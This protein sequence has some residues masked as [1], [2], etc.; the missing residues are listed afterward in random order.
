MTSSSLWP[1]CSGLY[2]KRPAGGLTIHYSIFCVCVSVFVCM[3]MIVWSDIAANRKSALLC[4]TA[5]EKK[6]VN[7]QNN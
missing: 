3:Q 2:L 4:M 5:E 7:E 1:H 6:T